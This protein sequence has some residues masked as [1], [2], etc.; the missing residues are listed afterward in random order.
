MARHEKRLKIML[1]AVLLIGIAALTAVFFQFRRQGVE[2][3]GSEVISKLSE[4]T[5]MSLDRVR[6]TA[7]KDGT[8]Q[9]E[10]AADSAELESGGQIMVLQSPRV[11]FFLKDGSKVHLTAQKGILNTT[12]NDMQVHGNVH[13]HNDRYTLSTEMLAYR[14]ERNMLQSDDPVRISGEEI[15]L[16]AATMIY[17]LNTNQAQFTG[18]VDGLLKGSLSEDFPL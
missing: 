7:T 18:Q 10:L 17:D 6:Q 15:D 11:D 1:A 14:H 12:S 3:L 8:V 5:I 16:T 13:V 2:Q 4:K 9:W